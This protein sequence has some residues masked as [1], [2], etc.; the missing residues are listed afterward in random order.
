LPKQIGRYQVERLIGGGAMGMIYAA[1]DPVIDRKVAIKLIRADL[2]GGTDKADYVARFQREARTAGRCTHPNIVS[3]YDFAVHEGNPFLAMEYV[4]AGN[5]GQ[6]LA[7]SGR[8]AAPEAVAITGQVLDALACAHGLGI[9]HRDVKPANILLLA[10]GHVKMT[11]FGIARF[12]SVELTQDGSVIGTPS[13][14]SPEQIRGETVDAR[15]DLFSTGV[16]LYEMLSGE[17]PFPGRNIAEITHRLLTGPLPDIRAKIAGVSASLA[18]VIERAL[19]KSPADRFASAADMALALRGLAPDPQPATYDRTVVLPR[20]RVAAPA[21]SFPEATLST[22]ERKLAQHVGPIARHLVQ[23]AARRAGS[24]DELCETLGQRIE[25]PD[26]RTQFRNDIMA[27][28]VGAS[29][30]GRAVVGAEEMR[31]AE[32]ELARH[33]GPIARILVKRASDAAASADEFWQLLATHIG[34]EADRQ[35]FLRGRK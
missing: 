29:A 11:D 1:H 18:A 16:V 25:H 3:I 22:I 17:R 2:L 35:A 32:Q 23:S 13:Y 4:E 27:S 30:V 28:Q 5:L 31:R 7:A 34:A 33:V 26:Q 9:V 21:P 14:M 10:N 24:L 15:S 12:D 19:A 8:F 20:P 6:A